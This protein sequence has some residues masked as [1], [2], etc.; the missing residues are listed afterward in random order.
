MPK[1]SPLLGDG[2]NTVSES[3]VSNT[4][5]SE[6]FGSHRV[7]GRELSEFLSAYDLCVKANSPSFS[8][9]SPSLPQNSVSSLSRNSTLETVFRPFPI[10]LGSRPP[11]TG[12][13]WALR[14]QNPRRAQ[15]TPVRGGRDPNPLYFMPNM[16]GRPGHWTMEMNGGTSASYLACTPCVFLFVYCFIRVDAEGLLDYQGRAGIISIV[17]W[18]LRPVIFGVDTSQLR[19]SP[20]T[21]FNL[22]FR[23]VNFYGALLLASEARS[24]QANCSQTNLGEPR[25]KKEPDLNTK[26]KMFGDKRFQNNSTKFLAELLPLGPQLLHYITL[27][28]RINFPDYVIILY[29]T[30]LVLNYFL[31]YSVIC[32]FVTKRTVWASDYIT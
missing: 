28:F 12:L 14:A 27:L 15:E 32:C 8:Q 25:H 19:N 3:T 5:L 24:S 30:E 26:N 22:N 4:E 20:G 13:S 11:L 10:Y 29:I 9:N 17:R 1:L 2:P 6:L 16:T 7:P 31:G 23:D 21:L 18:N